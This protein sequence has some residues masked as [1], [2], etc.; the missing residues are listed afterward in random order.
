M[1][2]LVATDDS[3]RSEVTSEQRYV[4]V[5]RYNYAR[6]LTRCASSILD[7]QGVNVRVLIIRRRIF[8]RHS[9]SRATASRA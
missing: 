3:L 1:T 6:F 5:P 9:S 4:V 8:R 7:Q 2:H